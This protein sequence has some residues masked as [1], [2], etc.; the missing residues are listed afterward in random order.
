MAKDN[1]PT[2]S[3][4]SILTMDIGD[5]LKKK[6]K[7]AAPKEGA[8]P[9]NFAKKP[10]KG[11]VSPKKRTMNFVHHKSSF[12][13][14]KIACILLVLVIIGLVFWKYGFSDQLAQKTAAYDNLATKQEQLVAVNARL[15]GYDELYQK[16]SRYSFGLMNKNEANMVDRGQILQL[17]ETI[18]APAAS[19]SNLSISGNELTMNVS[20]ITLEQASAIVNQLEA[21][22][23]V[24]YTS[25]GSATASDGVEASISI[26]IGLVKP[27]PV[28][29]AQEVQ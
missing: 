26:S 16:Y 10:I 25:I 21:N 13:V 5:L 22:P 24:S 14:T 29:A 11:A 18:V 19:V 27:A 23:I 7:T 8:T 15:A 17:V 6:P 2:E 1:K 28:V 12:N 3:K 4:Q 20:G 9:K